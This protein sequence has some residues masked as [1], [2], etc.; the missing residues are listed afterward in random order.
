MFLR[1]I[2][3]DVCMCPQCREGFDKPNY[4]D[5]MCTCWKVHNMVFKC[6]TK[7]EICTYEQFD[8]E[9]SKYKE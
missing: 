2:D 8:T 3:D 7:Y 6:S 1:I 9:L 4:K 5:D